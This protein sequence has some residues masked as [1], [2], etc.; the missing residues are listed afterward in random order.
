M[1]LL[2]KC[3][4]SSEYWPDQIF[5]F[6]D[7]SSG[8]WALKDMR[9]LP[10]SE[11]IMIVI[12]PDSNFGS[13]PHLTT[14]PLTSLKF[15]L[16]D[17]SITFT[18]IIVSSRMIQRHDWFFHMK[19]MPNVY[20]WGNDD[21]FSGCE[22]DAKLERKIQELQDRHGNLRTWINANQDPFVLKFPPEISSHFWFFSMDASSYHEL[23]KLPT[24]FLEFS[25]GVHLL[26]VAP[27]GTV[28]TGALVN[29]LA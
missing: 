1:G 10:T 8:I 7:G 6:H 25:S 12:G 13:I 19:S 20:A 5:Y 26:R 21:H 2:N 18:P 9:G 29:A 14:P 22:E 11:T 16:E 28:D 3:Q 17:L 23:K 4:I 24:S 15:L 27:L